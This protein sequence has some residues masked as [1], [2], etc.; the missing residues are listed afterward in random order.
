VE[1]LVAAVATTV[2]AESAVVATILEPNDDQL[3]PLDGLI[4]PIWVAI[5]PAVAPK[6]LSHDVSWSARYLLPA[7]TVEP[8]V[9]K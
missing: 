7:A 5:F 3:I 2:Y 4:Q 8:S 1:L 9:A 6:Q